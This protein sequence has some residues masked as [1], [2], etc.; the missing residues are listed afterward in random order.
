MCRN[1][2]SVPRHVHKHSFL[3]LFA[4]GDMYNWH[5]L[6]SVHNHMCTSYPPTLLLPTLL[7]PLQPEP[8]IT[9]AHWPQ[10]PPPGRTIL[11]NGIKAACTA[12]L[13]IENISLLAI[14]WYTH[15]IYIYTTYTIQNAIN[16]AAWTDFLEIYLKTR[17]LVS[18]LF[19]PIN[20]SSL[21]TAIGIAE[22]GATCRWCAQVKV[23]GGYSGDR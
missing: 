1:T 10:P 17:V 6:P 23:R 20:F 4:T 14:T 5:T 19:Y 2:P 8:F 12:F 7:P 15:E 9:G 11:Q 18:F 22:F 16:A 3:L 21:I 13:A